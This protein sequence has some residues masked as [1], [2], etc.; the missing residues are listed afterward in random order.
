MAKVET[1][2]EVL[3][4]HLWGFL[5]ISLEDDAWGISDNMTIVDGM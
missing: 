5:D 4:H 3:A 1:D 2:P